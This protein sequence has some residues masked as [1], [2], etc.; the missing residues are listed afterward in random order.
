MQY[1][2]TI[3]QLK[4]D[5]TMENKE[6]KYYSF[7]NANKCVGTN[8]EFVGVTTIVTLSN[9][10]KKDVNGKAVV[11]A[12]ARISNRSRTMEAVLGAP[13]QADADGSVW[14]DVAFW[15]DRA[16]RFMRYVGDRERVRVVLVG[17]M[18]QRTFTKNDGTEGKAV[19]INA[20]DWANAE[21]ESK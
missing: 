4:G 17:T 15:E 7:F 9:I 20:T 5:M 3:F 1:I 18:L 13:V 14:V 8:G 19:V 2:F 10:Q 12:R 6:K 16:E 21:K 11:N